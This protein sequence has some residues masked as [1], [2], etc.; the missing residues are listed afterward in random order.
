MIESTPEFSLGL[1]EFY[2]QSQGFNLEPTDYPC[3]SK[4]LFN[5]ELQTKQVVISPQS[6]PLAEKSLK[7]KE[8]TSTANLTS[9]GMCRC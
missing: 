1:K 5:S 9:Q 3:T 8:S 2:S 7:I 4:E 6:S